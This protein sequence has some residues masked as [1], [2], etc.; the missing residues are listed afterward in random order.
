MQISWWQKR[1][2]HYSKSG[3]G[4]AKT[5]QEIHRVSHALGC[6]KPPAIQQSLKM[7]GICMHLLSCN[8][9]LHSVLRQKVAAVGQQSILAPGLDKK[10]AT[11]WGRWNSRRTHWMRE[12]LTVSLKG[13]QV[14]STAHHDPSWC[15]TMHHFF[16]IKLRSPKFYDT[17]SMIVLL[18]FLFAAW[19]AREHLHENICGS[20]FM[21]FIPS[22][23]CKWMVQNKWPNSSLNSSVGWTWLWWDFWTSRGAL[24]GW[25]RPSNLNFLDGKWCLFWL[26][27]NG[28]HLTYCNSALF[29]HRSPYRSA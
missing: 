7:H 5:P 20:W 11:K 21:K 9:S 8:I 4:T 23:F 28:F 15:I 1:K 17:T 27:R 29:G 26:L 13:V 2:R 3:G 6:S 22:K 19:N 24:Q 10:W 18:T 14:R 25:F 12:V 16:T